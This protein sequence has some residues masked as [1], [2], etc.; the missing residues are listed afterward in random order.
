MGEEGKCF[1]VCCKEGHKAMDCPDCHMREQEQEKLN[2]AANAEET[3]ASLGN[4]FFGFNLG[5]H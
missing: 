1:D 3:V 4:F 5:N 2:N